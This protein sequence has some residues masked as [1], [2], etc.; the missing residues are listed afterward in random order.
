MAFTTSG[1]S[2]TVT[3]V[4]A[5]APSVSVTSY[6]YKISDHG[7]YANLLISDSIQET[8]HVTAT[9][10]VTPVPPLVPG[11]NSFDSSEHILRGW[12]NDIAR[13]VPVHSLGDAQTAG[14]V[15]TPADLSPVP[16]SDPTF[17]AKFL[18]LQGTP[19]QGKTEHLSGRREIG[20][21]V[22]SCADAAARP[23]ACCRRP[24][25]PVR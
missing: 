24:I 15:V 18:L 19:W 25:R 2:N 21:H 6:T 12:T 16:P 3:M 10:Y 11:N 8:L 20:D 1:S 17:S 22:L 7:V 9:D 13:T 5:S 14:I 4:D 23:S